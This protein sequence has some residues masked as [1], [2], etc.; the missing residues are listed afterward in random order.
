MRNVRNV[1][2]YVNVLYDVYITMVKCNEAFYSV[3][4]NHHL[5]KYLSSY[6]NI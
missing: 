1:I 6:R 2:K 3:V 4:N 5:A